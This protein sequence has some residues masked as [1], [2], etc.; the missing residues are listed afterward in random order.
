MTLSTVNHKWSA[1]GALCQQRKGGSKEA[2]WWTNL[3]SQRSQ[4]DTSEG[5]RAPGSDVRVESRLLSVLLCSLILG[6]VPQLSQS[7]AV[8]AGSLK[9]FP[10]HSLRSQAQLALGT[11]SWA[12]FL[13]F[14]PGEMQLLE[15]QLLIYTCM[16]NRSLH[17]LNSRPGA[18]HTWNRECQGMITASDRVIDASRM[19]GIKAQETDN[20][21][22]FI[23]WQ[24]LLT[25]LLRRG[26]NG[27]LLSR[28]LK[29]PP[30]YTEK[31]HRWGLI[32]CSR[33]ISVEIIVNKI[34]PH[35]TPWVSFRNQQQED[36]L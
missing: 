19:D 23:G 21:S 11:W 5:R 2:Q 4:G 25:L 31:R 17:V 30:G 22:S 3:C 34:N 24:K 6:A 1:T 29:T 27:N 15:S 28:L 10:V 14:K 35:I 13:C 26:G 9:I 16:R 33:Q 18:S 36:G 32:C 8:C 20:K 7:S 12:Y